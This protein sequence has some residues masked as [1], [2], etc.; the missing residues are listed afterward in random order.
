MPA[1]L[2]PL[3]E[4]VKNFNTIEYSGGTA[5]PVLEQTYPSAECRLGYKA[6][7]GSLGKTARVGEMAQVQQPHNF[8]DETRVAISAWCN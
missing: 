7:L 8:H 6:L 3:R 2:C 1:I 5:Q 4:I